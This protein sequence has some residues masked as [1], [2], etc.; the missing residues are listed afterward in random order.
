MVMAGGRASTRRAASAVLV[1][2]VLA[3]LGLV[4]PAHA[5][6]RLAAATGG[7]GTVVPASFNDCPVG[8]MCVFAATNGGTTIGWRSF[9]ATASGACTWAGIPTLLGDIRG[10]LSA[11]N[12]TGV[13]QQLWTGSNCTGSSRVLPDRYAIENLGSGHWSVGGYP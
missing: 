4:S 2:A 1:V 7:A 11:Y 5:A 9:R 13:S 8:L 12:R 3:S 6:G 10:Y